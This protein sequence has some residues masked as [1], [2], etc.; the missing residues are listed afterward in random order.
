MRGQHPLYYAP[1]LIEPPTDRVLC[2]SKAR[3]RKASQ[4][5]LIQENRLDDDDDDDDDESPRRAP[6]EERDPP[7]RFGAP[8]FFFSSSLEIGLPRPPTSL[9]RAPLIT[10]GP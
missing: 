4:E 6:S 2:S 5:K 3:E 7:Q 8:F 1:S 9:Q 10:L